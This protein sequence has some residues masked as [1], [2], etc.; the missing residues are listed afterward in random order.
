MLK[1]VEVQQILRGKRERMME[2]AEAMRRY[3]LA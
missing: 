1:S 3:T 2:R